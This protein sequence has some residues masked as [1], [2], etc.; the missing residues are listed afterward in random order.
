MAVQP[1]QKKQLHFCPL[2][3]AQVPHIAHIER[4][5]YPEPWTFNMLRNEL[6]TEHSYFAVMYQDNLLVG[7]A[8]YWLILDEAH[9][10]RVT[11]APAFRGQGLSRPLM[12][13]LINQAKQDNARYLRLEVR[14]SNKTAIRLYQTLGF[15]IEGRRVGYYY[16]TKEDAI[17]MAKELKRPVKE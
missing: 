8:G 1:E 3:L 11:I 4:D 15:V 13:H 5:A 16:K 17:V 7:Y 6:E 10:T 9:V 12:Y 2:T 14:E